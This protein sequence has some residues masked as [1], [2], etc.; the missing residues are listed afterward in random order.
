MIFLILFVYYGTLIAKER[1]EDRAR[2][3]E[4]KRFDENFHR[5][6]ITEEEERALIDEIRSCGKYGLTGIVARTRDFIWHTFDM[7]Y[8]R[9]GFGSAFPNDVI[10]AIE[11]CKRGK[12]N[13][14][15]RF[16]LPELKNLT[17]FTVSKDNR[18]K[19][20][21][22]IQDSLAESTGENITV[23]Y[24]TEYDEFFFTCFSKFISNTCVMVNDP[25]IYEVVS[26]PSAEQAAK[27]NEEKRKA[28]RRHY[29]CILYGYSK[30]LRREVDGL[31][32]LF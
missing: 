9:I 17:S 4:M 19:F 20:A 22:F 24:N 25:K 7:K 27:E 30:T 32:Y 3:A 12:V 10:A 11:L 6:A 26:G 14:G 28:G 15:A 21:K 18:I 13:R 8:A 23:A 5:L 16:R 2:E 1:I 29:N 31:P